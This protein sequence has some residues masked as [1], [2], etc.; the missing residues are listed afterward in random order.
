MENITLTELSV[1]RKLALFL[2]SAISAALLIATVELTTV[3]WLGVILTG[4][5]GWFTIGWLL[6]ARELGKKLKPF[7]VVLSILGWVI[8]ASAWLLRDDPALVALTTFAYFTALTLLLQDDQVGDVPAM[9]WIQ[10]LIIAPIRRIIGLSQGL[11]SV[12]PDLRMVLRHSSSQKTTPRKNKP[13]HSA[14]LPTKIKL[15]A[16]IS[17]VLLASVIFTLLLSSNTWLHQT[18]LDSLAHTLG[19]IVGNSGKWLVRLLF[20]W[21]LQFFLY[22]F[23]IYAWTRS[24]FVHVRTKTGEDVIE[25]GEATNL[26]LKLGAYDQPIARIVLWCILPILILFDVLSIVLAITV[27]STTYA[28]D[29]KAGLLQ[30]FVACLLSIYVAHVLWRSITDRS[31]LSLRYKNNPLLSPLLQTAR[32]LSTAICV[33]ILPLSVSVIWRQYVYIRAYG[34]TY[35]R[36]SGLLISA[37]LILFVVISLCRY[38][39]VWSHSK[40]VRTVM[41]GTLLVIAFYVT[42]IPTNRLILDYNYH[43]HKAG[44][45]HKFEV[46]GF[47]ASAESA[48][49]LLMLAKELKSND[50]NY[51]QVCT[52][53]NSLG[54]SQNPYDVPLNLPLYR[55]KKLLKNEYSD[56]LK[57]KC[58][59][60]IEQKSE[61]IY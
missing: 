36:V 45:L 30:L 60:A 11:V 4:L 3:H 27:K 9:S 10:T 19:V 52:G 12:I 13:S 22:S 53:L 37:I 5:I 23:L 20:T 40:Y 7:T 28:Q 17:G 50:P 26:T 2:Y 31:L 21:P 33:S 29:A 41:S 24:L 51:Y 59:A 15:M 39:F 43:Q 56:L 46:D 61:S 35:L 54:E 42:A 34:L 47:L 1:S 6:L 38:A 48:P 49:S 8:L 58:S 25:S 44:K 55:A 32:R 14:A 18:V 16:L 57:R